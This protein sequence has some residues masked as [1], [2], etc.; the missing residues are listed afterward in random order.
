MF[1]LCT[2]GLN[3]TVLA[4]ALSSL[5][6]YAAP[7]AFESSFSRS[8]IKGSIDVSH[9]NSSE[10]TASSATNLS[11]RSPTLYRFFTLQLDASL[12]KNDYTTYLV[13]DRSGTE[14]PLSDAFDS[15]EYS[16]GATLTFQK[17]ADS[18][19]AGYSRSLG[20]SPFTYTSFNFGYDRSLFYATS[21]VGLAYFS[22][23]TAQP[24]S[25][26]INREFQNV[27]RPLQLNARRFE[28]RFEQIF[29]SWYKARARVFRGERPEDRPHHFGGELRQAIAPFDNLFLQLHTGYQ[30]EAVSTALKNERGRFTVTWGE[31]QIRYQ[32][33]YDLTLTLSGGISLEKNTSLQKLSLL[34]WVLIQQRLQRNTPVV[35]GQ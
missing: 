7:G 33:I 12:N 18:L 35:A 3:S 4:I 26:F 31:L 9:L 32:P 28:F 11:L 15:A 24:G 17:G 13:G 1:R 27:A 5:T 19:V 10:L 21:K 16:A 14:T 6:V 29:T 25:F 23:A 22:Q 34:K 2:L 8:S 20:E 30:R